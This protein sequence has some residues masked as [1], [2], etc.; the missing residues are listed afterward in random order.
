[1]TDYDDTARQYVFSDVCHRSKDSYC[2]L[3]QQFHFISCC[4]LVIDIHENTDLLVYS[5]KSDIISHVFLL[6]TR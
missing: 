4:I 3:L 2:V 5:T 6:D 1:M